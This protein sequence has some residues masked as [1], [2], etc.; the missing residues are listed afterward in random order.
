MPQTR[1]SDKPLTRDELE[2]YAQRVVEKEA[3]LR[4][5]VEALRNKQQELEQRETNL[6]PNSQVMKQLME[7]FLVIFQRKLIHL[8]GGFQIYWK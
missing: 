2:L 1:S 5:Q 6:N 8:I 4:E 7:Q 3:R